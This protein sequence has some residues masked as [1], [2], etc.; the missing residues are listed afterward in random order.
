M[1]EFGNIEERGKSCGLIFMSWS[2]ENRR[3]LTVEENLEGKKFKVLE[4]MTLL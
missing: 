4:K 2:V 1:E 3:D